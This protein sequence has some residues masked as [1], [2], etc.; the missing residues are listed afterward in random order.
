MP[1][2]AES[3]RERGSNGRGNNKRRYML[4]EVEGVK[5]RWAVYAARRVQALWQ[6]QL[7]RAGLRANATIRYAWYART[8]YAPRAS[9]C[10]ARGV[11]V[12]NGWVR[13]AGLPMS[14]PPTYAH[15]RQGAR[16]AYAHARDIPAPFSR[17]IGRC[18]RAEM[19]GLK[20]GTSTRG[21]P[22]TA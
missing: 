19:L 6:R 11:A 10:C 17:R 7:P 8:P 12:G 21:S 5:M 16:A 13:S 15:A 9:V 1:R 18:W 4:A 20:F 14:P 3:A 22:V 2:A